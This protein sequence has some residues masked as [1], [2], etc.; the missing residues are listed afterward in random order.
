MTGQDTWPSGIGLGKTS[1]LIPHVT[2]PRTHTH[3]FGHV[4]ST[5]QARSSSQAFTAGQQCTSA[6]AVLAR[7]KA[8]PCSTLCVSPRVVGVLAGSSGALLLFPRAIPHRS[9]SF[10]RTFSSCSCG[11]QMGLTLVKS[12]GLQNGLNY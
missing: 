3:W 11:L 2:H 6:V 12:L 7:G 10:F 1:F 5:D 4:I 9:G 8:R